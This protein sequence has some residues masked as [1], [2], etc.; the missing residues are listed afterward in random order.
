MRAKRFSLVVGG[1]VALVALSGV[2]ASAQQSAEA[3]RAVL[4]QYCV[5]CHNARLTSG[6]LRLDTA[7]VTAVGEHGEVWE[8]V[9]RKLRG[10]VMPPPGNPRPEPAAYEALTSWVEGELDRYGED[11]PNPGRTESFHRLNRTEYQNIV[12]DLLALDM[13]FSD[14]LPIDDSG[15][16]EASFDNIASSLRLTQT[17]MEQYLSVAL[18]V[19]RSAVGGV[20]PQAE[21]TF[22]VADGVRQDVYTDG[23][24]FGTRGG[25]LVNHNFPVDGEY[26]FQV[27]VAGGGTGQLE[28]AVD[29]ERVK[30]FEVKPGGTASYGGAGMQPEADGYTLRLAV[31]AGP[32]QITVAF[33]KSSA[34]VKIEY[35]RTPFEGG[36][37]GGRM[38]GTQDSMGAGVAGVESLILK[39]PLTVSGAGNTPSRERIFTCRPATA[40]AEDACA[41]TVLSDLARRAYRRP[42]TD[43]DEAVLMGLYRDGRAEGDFEAGVERGIRGMLVN[44]SFLLRLSAEPASS[45]PGQ[46]YPVSDLEL[47]SRLSFFIWSTI[48]D[49]ELLDLAIAGQ[50]RQRG[51]L[52]KQVR[53]M[54]A[55]A[56]SV[57]LTNSFAS[58]WLW[59][60]NLK[61]ALPSEVHFPNFDDG[62]RAALE[63]EIRLF[64]D[65]IVRDD[66]SAVSLLD[67]DYTFVNERLAKHYGIPNIFGSDFRRVQ[68][69][70]DSPRRGLLGKGLLLLVTSRSTRT[71]PV[72]R[73]KWILENLLGTPPPAPPANVPPL[74]EQKQSD[75]RV[76]TVRELMA[77]HRANPVC[78]SC[79]ATIDPAGFALEQF[80]AVG[81]WRAVD[82]GFQPIDASGQLPDG[83][84]FGGINDFRGLLLSRREQF[85]R[86][87]TGK[88]TMYA[89]GR[90]LESY[91][92]PALRKIVR[93]AA[94]DDYKFSSLVLG[95]AKSIPFQMRTA[96]GAASGTQSASVAR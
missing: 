23:M 54:L 66:R 95:I 11:H 6:K 80:D 43:H 92:G 36:R 33:V 64:F 18:K 91:D 74:P 7:D 86:T 84:K 16:G 32:R 89:L 26:D 52:E 83:S 2:E 5:R 21:L 49:D 96:A 19:A 44:P 53:R 10:G 85:I 73:G 30:L 4:D 51:V 79:H 56:R 31:A 90:G 69:A 77:K 14:L 50:L 12:R 94:V 22:K 41:K 29:G 75:G 78:A 40:D 67:A 58:Q 17:L 24:P 65:S 60:R 27:T 55:D 46:V 34:S 35:D 72:V 57:S 20:P 37:G 71:S 1:C 82:T 87:L 13:D 62:L 70:A 9:V 42:L 76:L 39:G 15:G 25:L 45:T 38:R 61:A 93:D 88:L 68:L 8:K 28:L 48:P 3:Q 59:V 47:A 81:K 63:T